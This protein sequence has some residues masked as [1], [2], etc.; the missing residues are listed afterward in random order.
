M[1][2]RVQASSVQ[3]MAYREIKSG[4]LRGTFEPGQQ[5]TLQDMAERL[6][7][8]MMPVREAF[9]RLIAEKALEVRS[10]RSVAIPILDAERIAD[11]T[12]VRLLV[13]GA[14]VEWAAAHVTRAGIQRLA[15]LTE[16][17]DEAL[18]AGDGYRYLMGDYQFHFALYEH[19]G[20]QTLMPV[21]ES[22]WLQ[23]RPSLHF[24]RQ[25]GVD[26][27]NVNHIAIVSCLRAG[28]ASG[29]RTALERDLA[30]AAAKM[31]ALARAR[32]RPQAEA[33]DH[34]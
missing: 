14:A 3:E 2:Q 6:G 24:L 5:L 15:R 19:A 17:M 22:L 12:R 8:S 28:D 13:E 23:V 30:D 4:L 20:S 16:A 25:S 31:M 11:V 27:A 18:A 26:L 1:L 32:D 9:R 33:A 34:R 29:A 7:T 10:N 21:I